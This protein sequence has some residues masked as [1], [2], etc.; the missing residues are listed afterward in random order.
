MMGVEFSKKLGLKGSPTMQ[1][2][3][4]ILFLELVLAIE[5][6]G[7]FHEI[8]RFKIDDILSIEVE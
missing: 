1:R 7:I 4:F 8:K 6:D 2:A 5:H 3:F